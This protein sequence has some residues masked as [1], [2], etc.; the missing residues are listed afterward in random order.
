MHYRSK[1]IRPNVQIF[2]I[3]KLPAL[4]AGITPFQTAFLPP[5]KDFAGFWRVQEGVELHAKPAV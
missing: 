3:A 5:A 4:N 1:N 2:L